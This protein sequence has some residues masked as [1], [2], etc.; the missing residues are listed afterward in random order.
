MIGPQAFYHV[1]PG[2]LNH[3]DIGNQQNEENHANRN[4]DSTLRMSSGETPFSS[5][6][7]W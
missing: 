6:F 2:L 7:L 5:I 1:G 4:Q 3:M